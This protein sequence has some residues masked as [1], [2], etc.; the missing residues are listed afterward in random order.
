MKRRDKITVDLSYKHGDEVKREI[1][2]LPSHLHAHVA[3]S[4][5]E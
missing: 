2:C 3:F 4:N 1:L 5:V